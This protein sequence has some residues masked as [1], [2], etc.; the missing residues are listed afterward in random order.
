[1]DGRGANGASRAARRAAPP[2]SR[3]EGMRPE[4]YVDAHLRDLALRINSVRIASRWH[5]EAQRFLRD[6]RALFD[7]GPRAPSRA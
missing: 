3:D 4:R 5:L 1:M 2:D 7:V 6:L